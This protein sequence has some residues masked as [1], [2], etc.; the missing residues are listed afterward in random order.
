MV[1]LR[2]GAIGF[3]AHKVE[4]HLQTSIMTLSLVGENGTASQAHFLVEMAILG[5]GRLSGLGKSVDAPLTF[6]VTE[7]GKE[8][9]RL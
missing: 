4:N 9:Q 2:R 7:S 6:P 8:N 1:T 5:L 3:V